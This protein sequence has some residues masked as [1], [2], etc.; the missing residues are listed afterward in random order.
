MKLSEEYLPSKFHLG[1]DLLKYYCN[2]CDKESDFTF[3]QKYPNQHRAFSNLDLYQCTECGVVFALPYLSDQDLDYYYNEIWKTSEDVNIIY[4]IQAMERVRYIN[5]YLNNYDNLKILDIGS[6][7]GLLY[8]AFLS[9]Y[10]NISFHATELNPDNIERLQKKG[11]SV[12]RTISEI[13]EQKFDIICLCSVLEH[14][15]KPHEFLQEAKK[16]LKSNGYL[17]LDLPNRDDLF[18]QVLDPHV[19]FY[20]EESLRYLGK[21]LNLETLDICTYGKDHKSLI[22]EF[23]QTTRF[24]SLKTLIIKYITK[25]MMYIK[26]CVTGNW[27]KEYYHSY[28]KIHEEGGARWWIRGMFRNL[29]D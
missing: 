9:Q 25:I 6:G 3:L 22:Q 11:I 13:G 23:K 14:L 2:L 15:P 19:G 16:L 29:D 4:E 21:K 27:E 1:V 24:N 20:S 28:L 12:S 7:H 5:K 26:Y 17:F 18:K 8:D 10:N